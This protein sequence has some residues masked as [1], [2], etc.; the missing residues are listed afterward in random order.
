MLAP[1]PIKFIED[2]I[3]A[4]NSTSATSSEERS[5][6]RFTLLA[7]TG[8]VVQTRDLPL[9]VIVDI[10]GV[11]I[12][13]QK[14]PV[15]YEHRSFQG[16]G[17]TEKIT[18]LGNDLIAEGVM[19]RDTSWSRDILHSAKNGFP[20]QA[21]MG[22]PILESEYVA[23]DQEINVN[24]QTIKGELYV[25]R[26]MTLKEISFVDLGADS[27]TAAIVQS[28]FD[29]KEN[30]ELS[31]NNVTKIDRQ[32]SIKTE[33][34]NIDTEK[35][36][37]DV[38]SNILIDQRR[39]AA[40]E[41]IGDGKFPDLEAQAIES[42]WSVEK[43][44]AEYQNRTIPDASTLQKINEQKNK[45][46]LN[47]STLE[48]IALASSGSSIRYLESQYDE[49]TL[50]QVD[51]Y[52]GVGIQE[53]C[54]LACGSKYLPKYRRDSRGWLEAAFSSVSLPGILSNVANKVLLEGF[55][56]MDDTWKKIVKIASVNNFQTHTRYRMNG[57]FKY[58]K[59][60]QDGELKHGEVS[61]QQF[62]QKVGTYGLMFALTRQMIIDDDLSAFTDIPRAIGIGASDAI[63]DAV[64]SCILANATQKDGKPF[65]SVEHKNLV[66]GTNLDIEG[67][68]KAELAFSEQ[69][70]TP[71]RPLGIPAKILLVPAALKVA[72]ETLMKSLNVTV[73]TEKNKP[74]PVINPHAGKYEV[75]STPY[76]SSKAFK[77]NSATS[78]YLFADPI[79]L[80]AIEVAFLGGKDRPTVERADADFNILGVQF[81]GYIDFG[82]KEQDWRGTIKIV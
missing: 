16:V 23:P 75:V 29:D 5:L 54:E 43:F 38:Q 7:Y 62:S 14:I 49:S 59:V 63:S 47:A 82:V 56:Q 6:P 44:H 53:F 52:R 24:G 25:I 61:E 35:L 65:F 22:G 2:A 72:A 17:H 73:T 10:N 34:M 81:R 36:I 1:H 67:L 8:C 15:R 58:E 32:I 19:S 33:N 57:A 30:L 42:G 11:D 27:N 28:Q 31:Q 20:W 12:P 78:W 71:G 3:D 13:L 4:D 45:S 70:R 68:T 50:E 40:I 51:K 26:K 39:I 48:A 66:T 18:I 60:G 76:L 69:E 64:W 21:S 80:T 37:R 46:S 55:L 74:E 77:G 41:K 9:P 79:R